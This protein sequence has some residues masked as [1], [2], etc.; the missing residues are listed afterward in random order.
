ME[1]VGHCEFQVTKTRDQREA[2]QDANMGCSG[3][4]NGT[5]ILLIDD[6]AG[7]FKGGSRILF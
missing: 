7:D 3:R 6:L 2:R 4:K 5:L 1:K